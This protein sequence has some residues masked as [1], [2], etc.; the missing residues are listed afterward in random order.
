[1]IY[2]NWLDIVIIIIIIYNIS[3]GL[4]QGFIVSIFSIIGFILS[5]SIASRYYFTIYNFIMNSPILYGIFEGLAEIIL[6]IV[7][8]SRVKNNPRFIPDLISDGIVKV[9]IM[10]LAAVIVFMLINAL[11]NILLGIFSSVFKIPILKQLNKAGG[12]IFG[13]IKGVCIVYFL[14]IIFTPIAMFLPDS[15]IGRGVY[16]SLILLYFRDFNFF[17]L[18]LDYLPNK[19]YI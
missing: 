19:T 15:F 16:D 3:K 8:Y 6:T 17:D 12:M 9:I 2:L 13:L 11:V 7:F 4:K 18:M 5:I 10:V 14:S 1:M